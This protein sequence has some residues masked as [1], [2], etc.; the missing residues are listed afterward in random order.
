MCV[1]DVQRKIGYE[2]ILSGRGRSAAPGFFDLFR[3]RR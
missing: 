3:V 2:E 1:A